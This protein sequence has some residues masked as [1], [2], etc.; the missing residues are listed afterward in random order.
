[1][2]K[3]IVVLS[4]MAFLGFGLTLTPSCK[5]YEEGPN[6]LLKN[7]EKLLTSK[8]WKVNRVEQEGQTLLES[9][10]V[11]KI[12]KFAEDGRYLYS[13][14][15]IRELPKIGN[16]SFIDRKKTKIEIVMSHDSTGCVGRFELDILIL[17][18]SEFGYKEEVVGIQSKVYSEAIN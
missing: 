4:M 9:S 8:T 6:M 2:K 14:G 3:Q 10:L 1:M 15:E 11:P 5:K 13:Y 18:E 16:W 12:F 7:E 17:T